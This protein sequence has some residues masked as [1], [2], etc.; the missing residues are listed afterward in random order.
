[1]LFAMEFTPGS[2]ETKINITQRQTQ[3]AEWEESA[4]RLCT[5]KGIVTGQRWQAARVP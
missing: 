3:G 4:V 2:Q 1:M 5:L